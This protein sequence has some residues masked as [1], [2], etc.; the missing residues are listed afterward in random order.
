[1]SEAARS[2]R[3]AVTYIRIELDPPVSTFHVTTTLVVCTGPPCSPGAE[4]MGL[5]A[6]HWNLPMVAYSGAGNVTSN[7][8]KYDTFS[9][10][11]GTDTQFGR[12]VAP[13]ANSSSWDRVAIFSRTRLRNLSAT[14]IGV[15][16]YLML[17]NA[18]L[19]YETYRFPTE[20]DRKR[21]V[22]AASLRRLKKTCR[23]KSFF[24]VRG[25]RGHWP[26]GVVLVEQGRV[27]HGAVC[28]CVSVCVVCADL[29]AW[30]LWNRD[31]YSTEQYAC[32]CVC[33]Y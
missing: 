4:V 31:V 14:K 22:F 8:R 27:L 17:Q 18:T 32:V 12:V 13:L 25:G 10:T 23:G 28:V 29:M 11:R 33:V 16:D 6:S 19:V 24:L 7:R 21:D 1:M 20:A 9:R 15:A 3:V 30:C 26:H 2:D 5:L